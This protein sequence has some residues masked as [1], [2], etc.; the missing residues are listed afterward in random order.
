V[1]GGHTSHFI[2]IDNTTERKMTLAAFA[3]HINQPTLP[4]LIRRFLYHQLHPGMDDDSHD[5]PLSACPTIDGKISV[6]Y[7]AAATFHAPSDLSGIGGMRRE[8]IRANP[9]W[10]RVEPRY[11]CALVNSYPD[12]D[13]LRGFDVVR[14]M[15][16]FSFTFGGK[17]YP[18]ALVHWF[19]CVDDEP[20]EDTGMW[21]VEPLMDG[22]GKPFMSVIHLDCI[23]RAVHLIGVYGEDFVPV[24]L[25]YS[26][27]LDH[28]HTFYVNKF[29]DHHAFEIVF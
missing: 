9:L 25:H 19:A 7:S 21:I 10:Q 15:Q 4:R 26:Q 29:I 2:F 8:Y 3:L 6:H 1:S 23:L 27:S 22:A 28:F 14:I 11:D 12:R 20:D 16:F 18:C 5:I 24:K 17:I 13:G